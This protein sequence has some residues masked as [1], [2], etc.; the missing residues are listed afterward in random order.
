MQ[1]SELE[2]EERELLDVERGAHAGGLPPPP[3][4]G[5]IP[6]A[7]VRGRGGAVVGAVEVPDTDEVVE[8]LRADAVPGHQ[9]ENPRQV[10][11]DYDREAARE[12]E[13]NGPRR[14]GQPFDR[15]PAPPAAD[16]DHVVD[17]AERGHPDE[18]RRQ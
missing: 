13:H 8:A 5:R 12:P 10:A 7:T 6:F 14:Q 17:K 2:A 1:V 18:G 16:F 4:L 3:V 11:D 9:L 15:Y